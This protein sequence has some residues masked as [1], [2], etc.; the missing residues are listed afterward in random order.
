MSKMTKAVAAAVMA[1]GASAAQAGITIPAGDWTVDIGGNVNT[2]YT[3][4][5]WDGDLES[6]VPG[7]P[8][9]ENANQ[10]STGL[11]PSALVSAPRPVRTTWTSLFNSHSS[12]APTALTVVPVCSVKTVQAAT[13][14]TF[15]KRSPLSV[16]RAGVL[17]SSVAIWAS[18]VLTPSCPT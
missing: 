1:M 11:L 16:T 14:S 10:I 17:S 9:S 4:T 15:V 6:N 7:A 12:S 2:Y 8:T 3:N 5:S 18:S 13:A